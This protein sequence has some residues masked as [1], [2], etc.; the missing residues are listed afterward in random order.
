MNNEKRTE[1]ECVVVFKDF[2]NKHGVW[3]RTYELPSGVPKMIQRRFGGVPAF[4][5]KHALGTADYT[6]GEHRSKVTK[7][8]NLRGNQE[9]KRVFDYL[10]K[11]F[12]RVNVHRE[13]FF[14]D[15]SRC[16]AD[17]SVFLPGH[18]QILVDTFFASNLISFRG[19]LQ[20]KIKKYKGVYP[21]VL[22][23]PVIFIHLNSKIPS[24]EITEMLV[25]KTYPLDSNQSLMSFG[26]FERYLDSMV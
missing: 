11:R 26:E 6:K 14:T 21:N 13:Y 15:D 23:F 22:D 2:F 16:R 1:E 20:S 18:K 24:K 4:R 10:V 19:C 12:G 8:F 3:P 5:T 25:R 9:E 7:E 17:F